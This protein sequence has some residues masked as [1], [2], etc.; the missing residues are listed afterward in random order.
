MKFVRLLPLILTL[1]SLPLK[2]QTNLGIEQT[3]SYSGT[4]GTLVQPNTPANNVLQTSGVNTFILGVSPPTNSVRVYVTNDS[5]NACTNFSIQ[6]FSTGSA[7]V[8]SFNNSLASWQALGLAGSNGTFTT[9]AQTF[10]L[11][12]TSTQTFTSS[13]II[14]PRITVQLLITAACATTNFEA[15][16]VFGTFTSSNST[17]TGTVA[18]GQAGA[19]IPPVICGGI[20]SS[21]LVRSCVVQPFNTTGVQLNGLSI[22]GNT[23][24]GSA[25]FNNVRT[26]G[27]SVDG[28]LAVALF[29]GNQSNILF[30]AAMANANC[31][32]TAN[33]SGLG[34][35]DAGYWTSQ[36]VALTT[37]GQTVTL[38]GAPAGGVWHSAFETCRFD[39][40]IQNA[41]GTTPTLDAFIQDS[42]DGSNFTDRVRFTQATTG[43][44]RMQA[45]IAGLTNN[46]TVATYTDRTIAVGT[47][48]NGPIGAYG[49]LIVVITGTSPSYNVTVT[50]YCK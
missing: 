49:R 30:P 25:T 27:G 44:L 12:G 15:Q 47:I 13:P 45:G 48:V 23:L 24:V 21:G 46:M 1:V 7:G 17:V 50:A 14:G 5:A 35:A 39:I 37:T 3:V 43:S 10:T 36:G 22:G 26:P 18:P 16:V 4:N 11:S 20:D 6:V 29:A 41:A 40:F 9:A 8:T 33:C 34:V 32:T 42:L 31:N 38:W 28:P 19:S 2:A